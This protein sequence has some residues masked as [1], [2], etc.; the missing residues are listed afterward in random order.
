MK[1]TIVSLLLISQLAFGAGETRFPKGIIGNVT[2]DVTGNVSGSAATFTG[3]LSGDV[4]STGMS[5]SY[6]ATVPINKGGTGATTANNAL[7]ALLPTQTGNA[8]KSLVTD[9]TNSSWSAASGSGSGATNFLV[10]PN[11]EAGT[12][13]WTATTA[14][15]AS[16]TT[17][18]F[19]GAKSYKL[20]FS[21]QT[22]NVAQSVTA[23]GDLTGVNLEA[24]CMVKTSLTT[25]QVCSLIAGVEQQ[26]VA[27]PSTNTW[28]SVSA[29]MVGTTTGSTHGV[30]VKTTASTTGDVYVD[31]C[32]VGPN[33]NIGSVSQA[34]IYGSVS[35]A[36]TASCA[37]T[38][39]SNGS[40][41][42]FSEDTDCPT[43]TA[44][45]Y[46]SAPATR[47]PA[48]KFASLPPGE[49]EVTATGA[50]QTETATG[51][52]LFK[53]T[54][55][56][57]NSNTMSVYATSGTARHMVLSGKFTYTTAAA[58]TIEIQATG[59]GG[60]NACGVNADTSGGHGLEIVVKRF[61]TQ[62]ETAVRADQ[63]FWTVNATIGG[64]NF[65]IATDAKTSL[66]EMTD[67][68][69]TLTNNTSVA[70][71]ISALIACATTT[72]SSGT[73]CT[74]ANESNGIAFTVPTAGMIE[75]CTTGAVYTPTNATADIGFAIAETGN[76]NQTV[77][78]S[79]TEVGVL[80]NHVNS[81]TNYNVCG[82]FNLATAGKHTFRLMYKTAAN[83]ASPVV[84]ADGTVGRQISWTAKPVTANQPAPLLVG[85]VTSSSAGMT[86]VEWARLNTDCTVASQSGSW[87]T[88]TPS[89]PATGRCAIPYTGFSA[90]PVCV[91]TT[92]QSVTPIAVSVWNTSTTSSLVI[93]MVTTTASTAQDSPLLLYCIGPR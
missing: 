26:C 57:L 44:S 80:Y 11:F 23:P 7:N 27:V 68:S 4:T 30:Y 62:A 70:N 43:A 84:L 91:G 42:S 88:G 82:L 76:A 89:H 85:S 24:S 69:M 77:S 49:Y 81:T 52:C 46:A 65:T 37:W 50:F 1:K 56:T 21:S 40:Y 86:R 25:I 12:G 67:G 54:D 63:T 66:T 10:N 14:T 5:T 73:T 45:G 58:R 64:S 33:R 47:I 41:A 83:S 87:I 36:G 18:I 48:I 16:E 17:T 53:F 51:A 92:D 28:V 59:L 71:A 3:N 61:P 31:D 15:G 35:T 9:G 8:G 38:R 78:S 20:S 55:G 60:S 13:S 79:G 2:G 93:G 6:S 74:A 72:E 90:V 75:V 34:S 39:T 29:T 22:G 32:L 19:N